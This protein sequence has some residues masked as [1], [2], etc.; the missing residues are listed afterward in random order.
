MKNEDK[1]ALIEHAKSWI[2]YAE[3]AR[4]EIPFGFDDDTEKELS[5]IK[6]ALAALTAEPVLYALRFKNHHGQP[7]KLI[8]ENCL[9]RSR[10]KASQYGKGGNYV[11]QNDGRIEWVRNPSLDPEVVPLF[12]AGYQVE[13]E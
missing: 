5:L 4:D 7:D 8:N 1:Q 10:E 9:F 2:A 6:I 11:T 13:G 3:A 12:T